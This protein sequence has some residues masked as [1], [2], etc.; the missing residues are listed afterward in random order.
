LDGEIARIAFSVV[1]G[2]E[3]DDYDTL[4][5]NVYVISGG[6][7]IYIGFGK[8]SL[9]NN[10]TWLHF[11]VPESSKRKAYND[12]LRVKFR[13]RPREDSK[14]P[15]V[16]KSCGFHRIRRYEEKAINGI[17]VTKRPHGDDDDDGMHSSTLGMR[18]RCRGNAPW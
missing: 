9:S 18:N 14:R 17:Q 11:H 7:T 2:L 15:V 10:T 12:H 3:D 1:V 16:F 4:Q 6:V 8:F 5:I 13:V